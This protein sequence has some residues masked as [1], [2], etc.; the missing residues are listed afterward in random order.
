[1]SAPI[2]DNLKLKQ[3]SRELELTYAKQP[4][5]LSFEFLR[6]HSPSA[7][8]RGHGRPVLVFAKREVL[9]EAAEPV[10]NYGVKF[11]FDDGHDSGIYTWDLLYQYCQDRDQMWQQYLAQL[12]AANL[13]R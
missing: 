2:P 1:M 7:E 10:G 3:G 5:C 11:I 4:Y 13:D 9:I 12:E 6:V 8:V